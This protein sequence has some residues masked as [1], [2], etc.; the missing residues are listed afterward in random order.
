MPSLPI[1]RR[2]RYRND[3]EYRNVVLHRNDVYY[4][5]HTDQIKNWKKDK[6][7]CECGKT[8]SRGN[9]AR[10]KKTKI[11]N[12]GVLTSLLLLPLSP[13]SPS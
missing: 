3:D 4:N 10:H 13:S 7:T 1:V 5:T 2:E 12:D 8:I 6:I 9:L 11:H